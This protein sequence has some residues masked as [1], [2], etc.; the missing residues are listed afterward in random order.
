MIVKRP[1]NFLKI[2]GKTIARKVL[3][4]ITWGLPAVKANMSALEP[5]KCTA[6]R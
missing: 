4:F 5:Q 6:L 3:Q 1:Q 2:L